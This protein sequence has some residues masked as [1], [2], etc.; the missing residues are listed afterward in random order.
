MIE[1][2]H[3]VLIITYNCKRRIL[4]LSQL[5]IQE[6]KILSNCSVSLSKSKL[7]PAMFL[8][9]QYHLFIRKKL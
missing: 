9:K 5:S 6:N 2:W 3:N 7:F 4:G 8:S 1:D